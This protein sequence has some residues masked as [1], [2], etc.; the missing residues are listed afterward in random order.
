MNRGILA[1]AFAVLAATTAAPAPAKAAPYVV[2][3]IVRVRP[4]GP[5]EIPIMLDSK[6]DTIYVLAEIAPGEDG[7]Y[8]AE[9]VRLVQQ[10]SSSA[11]QVRTYGFPAPVPTCPQ[12]SLCDGS[13]GSFGLRSLTTFRAAAG[14]RILVAGDPLRFKVT[15]HSE[16]WALRRTTLGFRTVTGDQSDA[17]G[18]EL[19]VNVEVFRS[20]QAAGGPHG[21]LAFG[22][23][24]CAS[25]GTGTWTLRP[26][27]GAPGARHVCA[28]VFS[29]S[30]F[31]ETG[32]AGPW[33]L[34]GPVAGEWTF[35]YR[36]AVLDY[37]R[38]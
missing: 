16:R 14:R 19:A 32:E 31:A 4:G 25:R 28:P 38:R 22:Q 6:G 10:G 11:L 2:W 1:I 23:V 17:A 13:A 12:P 26:A 18:A 27:G 37:P 20:A 15:V 3:E 21:S 33:T 7:G 36:L 5:A 30:A 24:P 35:P 29:P 34:E 8:Q 9:R